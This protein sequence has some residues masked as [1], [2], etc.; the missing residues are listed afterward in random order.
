MKASHS[1]LATIAAGCLMSGCS[2]VEGTSVKPARPVRVQAL[3]PAAPSAG[4]R[5]SAAIEA[6][7]QVSL[8]FKSAGYVDLVLRRSGADGRMRT[9]QPG[10]LVGRGTVLARVRESDYRERVNQGR[11]QIDEA[12]AS[13]EK[14]RLDLDRARILFAADSLTKPELDAAQAAYDS[15]RARLAG[16]RAEVEIATIALRDSALI[17]PSS[18]VILERKI[19]FGSLVASGTV[20]FVIGDISAVKAR[21]GVPDA[22]IPSI[23]LGETISLIVDSLGGAAFEGRVTAIAPAAD[24][25]SRVFDVEVTIPNGDNRL[26]PGM[27]GNVSVRRPG[28][29]AAP[30]DRQTIPLTAVVRARRG[31]RQYGAFV[32][33]RRGD[34]DIA[35]MRPIELG[36]VIGN[37]IVIRSG[38]QAGERVVVTGASLLND[39]EPV[40]IIP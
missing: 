3:T 28:A 15:G 22:M 29:E 23:T 37:G 6:F 24:P 40:R 5:Y 26:R 2:K 39:G 32:I 13:V 27:I 38:I 12:A 9:A 25:A 4:I 35:R 17:A 1:V 20:G 36:D 16:S 11:A 30:A 21:F 14:A 34:A 19:E 31:S 33:E 10:D 7:E 18:G 8:S